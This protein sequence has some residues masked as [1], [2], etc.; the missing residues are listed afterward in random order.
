[1]YVYICML[2]YRPEGRGLVMQDQGSRQHPL[3][4]NPALSVIALQVKWAQPVFP[5]SLLSTRSNS[6]VHIFEQ[7][8]H[9]WTSIGNQ[10]GDACYN[11]FNCFAIAQRCSIYI[12][13]FNTM[14]S[15]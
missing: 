13:L 14:N 2:I 4:N 1:M 12:Q 8:S 9:K 3:P 7:K 6:P 5:N 15:H 10:T 11:S